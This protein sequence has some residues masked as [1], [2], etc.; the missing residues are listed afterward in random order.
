MIPKSILGVNSVS[1]YFLDFLIGKN[2]DLEIDGKQ[3]GYNERSEKDI[4]RDEILIKNG[5]VV[6]RIAWN[7]ITSDEGSSLMKEK[8]DRF[9]TWLNTVDKDKNYL[10]DYE[11][12]TKYTYTCRVCGKIVK[13]NIK[14][15]SKY[16]YCSRDCSKI[17][18]RM[19]R[20]NI[21]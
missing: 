10:Q 13:T 4:E 1:M 2:I 14:K 16:F 17:V 6:Y 8:I 9:L 20:T 3:H 19:S 12:P 15:R 18:K 5:Y 11:V 21:K 7:E